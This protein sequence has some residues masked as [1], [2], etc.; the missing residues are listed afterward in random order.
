MHIPQQA[1][2]LR[3]FTGE[4]DKFEGRLLYKVVVEE[5]R[6]QGLAGATVLRGLMGYGANSRV[7]ASTILRLSEDLPLI[8]EIV[9]APGKIEKFLA[10]LDQR[11]VEG[12]VTVEPVEVRFYRH[13]NGEKR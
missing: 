10:F 3:I 6:Q 7:H 9:D 1:V 11:L 13:F 2:R 12:L 8:I 5:A 4:S